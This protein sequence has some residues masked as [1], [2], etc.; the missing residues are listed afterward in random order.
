MKNK[1]RNKKNSQQ[2][3]IQQT[4]DRWNEKPR[5]AYMVKKVHNKILYHDTKALLLALTSR[6]VG[7]T[8]ERNLPIVRKFSKWILIAIC[9]FDFLS[10]FIYFN[11]YTVGVCVLFFSSSFLFNH[12][13]CFLESRCFFFIHSF[14]RLNCLLIY[15]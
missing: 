7:N 13:I 8:L 9:S 11:T 3:P 10:R 1:Q 12:L 6:C 14:A 4:L 2:R 5:T 15:L